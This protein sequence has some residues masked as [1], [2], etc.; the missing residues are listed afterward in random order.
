MLSVMLTSTV[1]VPPQ[2]MTQ[3]QKTVLPQL[4]HRTGLSL[5]TVV[6]PRFQVY[7]IHA[8]ATTDLLQADPGFKIEPCLGGL[9]LL[10]E[11][12]ERTAGESLGREIV[13]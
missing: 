2:R 1:G 11:S 7:I 5:Q 8:P 10:V 9:E 4:Q 3:L 6:G 13:E 12:G